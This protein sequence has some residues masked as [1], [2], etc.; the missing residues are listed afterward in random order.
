MV[1]SILVVGGAALMGA[2]MQSTY[3]GQLEA[4]A[5]QQ[6]GRFALQWIERYLRAAGN[7]PYRMQTTAC[8]AA[9]TPVQAIRF[10]P[11]GNGQDDDIRIQTDSNP[12]DG[13]FGGI[14]GTCNQANED[15]T[16]AFDAGDNTITVRDN[17]TGAAAVARTDNVI[18]GS[19][20]HLPQ[21]DRAWSPPTRARWPSSKR[22]SRC[23][24]RSRTRTS[25]ISS[26]R[27]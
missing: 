13:L 3:R 10:D 1:V 23:G 8:P 2:Q 24:R 19:A 4:A 5:A 11:N 16:I 20:V 27:P 22:A 14:A 25:G 18:D 26:S 6:E 7:N 17:V 21:P 15:V 9:G 12:T